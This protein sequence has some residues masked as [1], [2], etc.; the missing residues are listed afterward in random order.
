M[1]FEV[2]EGG[3]YLIRRF[4]NFGPILIFFSCS[5]LLVLWM[6]SNVGSMHDKLIGSTSAAVSLQSQGPRI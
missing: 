1:K 3:R 2:G 6:G 4:G 5:E